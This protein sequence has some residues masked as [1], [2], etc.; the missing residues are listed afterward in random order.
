M[1]G[2]FPIILVCVFVLLPFVECFYMPRYLGQQLASSKAWIG[3]SRV[4]DDEII[5]IC[6]MR[7]LKFREV[8]LFVKISPGTGTQTKVYLE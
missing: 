1:P 7:K 8:Q 2:T 5:P 3:I 4:K 6:Q